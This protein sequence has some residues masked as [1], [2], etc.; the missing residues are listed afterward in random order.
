VINVTIIGTGNV[1][2][3]LSEVFFKHQEINLVEICGRKKNLPTEFN[4]FID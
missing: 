2:F 3:H 4:V 1:A